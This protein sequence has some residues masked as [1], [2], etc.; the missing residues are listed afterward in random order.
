MLRVVVES[1]CDIPKK[2]LGTPDPIASVVFKGEEL[3][4][5]TLTILAG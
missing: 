2:K 5:I 1:A 4:T 3:M